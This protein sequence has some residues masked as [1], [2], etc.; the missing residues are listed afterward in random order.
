MRQRRNTA[1]LTPIAAG[2]LA[3]GATVGIAHAGQTGPAQVT[4]QDVPILTGWGQDVDGNPITPANALTVNGTSEDGQT[5]IY[6]DADTRA[7]DE[8]LASDGTG[9]VG[10]ISW[11]LDVGGGEAPGIQLIADDDKFKVNNCIMASGKATDE[12]TGELLTVD[13]TCSDYQGSSKRYKLVAT[14]ANAPIDLVFDTD[15]QPMEYDEAI[16]QRSGESDAIDPGVDADG[17]GFADG[18]VDPDTGD[19]L[20]TPTADVEVGRIYRVIQ[21]LINDTDQ[22]I[23][24]IR[25]QLGTGTGENFDPI[26][27]LTDSDISV[28]DIGFELRPDISVSFFGDA[29]PEDGQ[30]P[31][32]KE[33]WVPNEFAVLS[34]SMYYQ[35]DD[36]AD[37]GTDAYRFGEGFFD[38]GEGFDGPTVFAGLPAEDPNPDA[39]TALKTDSIESG[40]AEDDPLGKIG[41]ITDNYFDLP[42]YQA[43]EGVVIDP[44]IPDTLNGSSVFGYLLPESLLPTGIYKDKD[45]DPASEGDL[46]AWWDGENWRYGQEQDFAIVPDSLLA[47]WAERPLSEDEVLEGP[48]YE[49]AVIDDLRSVNMDAFIYLGDGFLEEDAENPGTF[50]PK[51]ETITLRVTAVPISEVN[52]GDIPGSDKPLWKQEGNEAPSLDSYLDDGTDTDDGITNGDD[53]STFTGSGGGGGCTVGGN[54]AFDPLLPGLVLAALG[55]LGLRRRW[56][57]P[58]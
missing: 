54:R 36:P 33:V 6:P 48:R 41:S 53:T 42:A 24:N 46:I 7:T 23:V 40:T 1:R 8:G 55:Y 14:E 44:A 16:A 4:V 26:T 39:T 50:V 32:T 29:F 30:S 12:D 18:V 49:T 43:N 45:G 5:F 35:G 17:D 34:P 47:E 58:L 2:L 25:V 52:S 57:M 10:Y 3:M 21:K 13:K 51:E 56:K 20:T 37:I 22:R 28:D 11:S 19:F 27:D 31:Y 38:A 15:V 9:S